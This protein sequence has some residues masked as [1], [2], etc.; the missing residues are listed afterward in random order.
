MYNLGEGLKLLGGLAYKA[1]L[2]APFDSSRK[3]IAAIIES[4]I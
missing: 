3:I 1:P 4:L 2:F